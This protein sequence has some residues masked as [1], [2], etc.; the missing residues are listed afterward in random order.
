MDIAIRDGKL[1]DSSF[2][3]QPIAPGNRRILC[4]SPAYPERHG[5][6]NHPQDLSGNNCLRF[7]LGDYTHD[8]WRFFAE[9]PELSA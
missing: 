5:A 4:A 3:A 6:P 7:L 1:P 9:G 2:V 8:R